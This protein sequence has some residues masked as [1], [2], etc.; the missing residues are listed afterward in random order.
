MNNDIPPI[1]L[2]LAK[3]ANGNPIAWKLPEPGTTDPVVIVF[4]DGRK[5]KF[6]PEP[7]PG[8]FSYIEEAV[9]EVE[10]E[11]KSRSKTKSKNK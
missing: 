5:L 8:P 4:E 10:Q 2:E 9:E 6:A 11:R 1:V 3:K 7:K